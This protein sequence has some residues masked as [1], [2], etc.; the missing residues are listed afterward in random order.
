MNC[1]ANSA[2]AGSLHQAEEEA[3]IP[4]EERIA[5]AYAE[6]Q[7]TYTGSAMADKGLLAFAVRME[8]GE[9]AGLVRSYM[10]DNPSRRAQFEALVHALHANSSPEALQVLLSI[11]RR[12]RMSSVQRTAEAL[13]LEAAEERGW[14]AEEL[15]DRTIPTAGFSDDG[16]LHMSYGPREFVGRLTPDFRVELADAAGKTLKSLPAARS[17]E[18]G[19]AVKA[20]KKQLTA[21]RKEAR[22]VL[23]LQSGRLYEAMCAGR[24]WPLADKHVVILEL[25][26]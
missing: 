19:D 24:T 2:W 12:H 6:H 17:G 16:L 10:R 26:D 18:D 1:R 25:T 11:A 8:G 4:L 21:A 3:A 9:L 15:A 13:A 20:A 14:S 7:R 5:E 22:A 23:T